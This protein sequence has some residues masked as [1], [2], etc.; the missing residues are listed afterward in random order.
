MGLTISRF[1]LW[2]KSF[3]CECGRR[4]RI[5][6]EHYFYEPR[7]IERLCETAEGYAAEPNYLL[8]ADRR[9]YE[10][11]G[12]AVQER[13]KRA[14]AEVN[15]YIVQDYENGESPKTDDL[16]KDS[17]LRDAPESQALIA[18]GSG[19]L[20]DLT[21]W[22][23][24]ERKKPFFAVATAASMN[25]YASANV[26]AT[27]DGLKVLFHAEACKGVFAVPEIIENAPFQLTASGLGDVLAKTVSSADWKI[28]QFLFGEYYCQ[29]IVDLI[30][31]LDPVY[32][33]NSQKIASREPGVIKALFEA[34][35]LSGVAMTLAG[36]SAP[37]SGGEHLISHAIDMVSDAQGQTHDFH[38]RQ[39]GVATIL[40]AA[41][42]EK[43]LSVETPAFRLPPTDIDKVFWGPL[44]DVVREAFRK[45][46]PKYELSIRE[47]S[48]PGRWDD[49]RSTLS[50][51]LR[52]PERLKICL[53]QGGAAHRVRDIRIGGHG[54]EAH[55][56][57]E[58]WKNAYQMRERFT[59]LDLALVVGILPWQMEE[60]LVEMSLI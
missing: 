42:Y 34:L 9:T 11:A 39:V 58:F 4:H 19:V 17:I 41:L 33:E 22:V 28:N 20:N 23:A 18:V 45:K 56:F 1:D 48:R 2:G 24:F 54:M 29:Y 25:G 57:M 5:P 47:L 46:A 3:D 52:S 59:I 43:V 10:A 27:V 15:L 40:S 13:L 35:V 30:S 32:L 53:K 38:G 14:G 31:R 36:S 7:A 21:K 16:T 8:I 44:S 37:A 50:G 49:L 26:A 6:T 51:F 60:I 55:R 12:A